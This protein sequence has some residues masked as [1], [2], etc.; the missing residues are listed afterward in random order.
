M[1]TFH[2]ISLFFLHLVSAKELDPILKLLDPTKNNNGQEDEG[3]NFTGWD[4]RCIDLYE[5]HQETM[6]DLHM[7]L[8]FHKLT[9]V[10]LNLISA[11]DNFW[12]LKSMSFNN[13]HKVDIIT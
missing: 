6:C 13:M 7:E 5:N 2:V 3:R 12:P 4:S 10:D 9:S 8:Y 11:S 1:K